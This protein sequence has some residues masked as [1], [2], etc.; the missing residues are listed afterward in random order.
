M[1][2]PNRPLQAILLSSPPPSFSIARASR[3]HHPRLRFASPPSGTAP[4]RLSL[5]SAVPPENRP[6]SSAATRP[7]AAPAAA[8]MDPRAPEPDPNSAEDFVH[9]EDPDPNVES[10]S[11]SFVGVDVVR[12]DD[13]G[14]EADHWSGGD[15]DGDDGDGGGFDRRRTLPEE[16]SRSVVVLTCES[17]A[18]GGGGTCDVYLVGTAHVSEVSVVKFGALN[19]GFG[20]NSG[21]R[22]GN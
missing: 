6:G 17:S 19:F 16:L 3:S 18:E 13:G 4:R 7:P 22:R 21:D 10:L 15:G 5:S 12:E 2:R 1:T 8:A 9:I 11:E 14:E 20:M